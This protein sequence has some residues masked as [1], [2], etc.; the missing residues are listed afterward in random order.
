MAYLLNGLTYGALLMVLASGLALMYG[1]RGVMN[2]AHGGLYMLAA[3]LGYSIAERTNFWLALVAAPAVLGLVGF[4]AERFGLRYLTHREILEI[5]LITLGVEFML[6]YVVR[7][8]WGPGTLSLAAPPGLQGSLSIF[9]TV[10]PTY[11]FVVL[12]VGFVLMALLV[13]WLQRSRIGLYVRA[14]SHDRETTSMMGVDIDRVSTAVVALSAGLAGFAGVLSAPYVPISPGMGTE[15]LIPVL[16][17]VVV[18]G[19]GSVG[20]AAVAAL[21]Y[22]LI[23]TT[24]TTYLPSVATVLPF[25]ALIAVLVLRPTGLAGQ[26]VH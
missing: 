10:Y 26:R 8:V 15:I 20:G 4:F 16:I 11:R 25:A 9:G 23:S 3:Y 12:V 22:G 1:L 5:A 13:V 14:A 24:G 21:G 2:L 19:L 17:I 18:G 7:L 6:E